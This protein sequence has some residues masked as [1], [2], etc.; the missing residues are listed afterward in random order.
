M[1]RLWR[2]IALPR[3]TGID[4]F[5]SRLRQ[6]SQ[7]G[8]IPIPSEWSWETWDYDKQRN[9]TPA[10]QRSFKNAEDIWE[11][12]PQ[13]E[14]C[15]AV[16]KRIAS[17]PFDSMEKERNWSMDW[18]W[19]SRSSNIWIETQLNQWREVDGKPTQANLHQTQSKDR[20]EG[21]EESPQMVRAIQR[22]WWPM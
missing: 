1:D 11:K 3:S 13:D 16:A 19:V 17:R 8:V 22:C 2:G 12:N 10:S 7:C 15:R 4:W 18:R 14:E 5:S 21:E 20:K 9:Y 6:F